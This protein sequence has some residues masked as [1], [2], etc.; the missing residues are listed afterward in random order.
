[1]GN[2]AR[3]L[4]GAFG[5]WLVRRVAQTVEAGEASAGLQTE[6]SKE[7]EWAKD[8]PQGA[9]HALAVQDIAERLSLSVDQAENMLATLEPQPTVTR[10]LVLRRVVEA[11][12]AGQRKGYGSR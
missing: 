12:V 9:A 2:E 7:M 11:W 8:L 4:Q 5:A 3:D 1:M 10:E 6:L